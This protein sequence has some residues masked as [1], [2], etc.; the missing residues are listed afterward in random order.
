MYTASDI[1]MWSTIL[2]QY[3]VGESCWSFV[4]TSIFVIANEATNQV[5][6]MYDALTSVHQDNVVKKLRP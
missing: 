5:V 2:A 1:T 4:K 3:G 6:L